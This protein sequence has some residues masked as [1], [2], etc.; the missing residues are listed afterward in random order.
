[1]AFST[2]ETNILP[3]PIL[4]VLA[5]FEMAWTASVTASQGARFEFD[6]GQ[7]IDGV[8]AAAID[9]GVAFLAAESL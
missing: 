6:F 7:E 9:F 5:A 1:M 4:P 3:S 8:L 2:A